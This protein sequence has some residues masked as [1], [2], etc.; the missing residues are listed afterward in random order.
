MKSFL[1]ISGDQDVYRTIHACLSPTSRVDPAS[2]VGKALEVL[3]KRRY[4]L[5]FVDLKF[6][7]E[8]EPD[9]GYKAALQTFWHLYPTIEIIV[10]ASNEMIREAVMCVKAGASDYLTYPLKPDEVSHVTESIYESVILQSELEYLRDQ[11]WQVDSLEVVQTRNPLMRR[12]FDK[13]RSVASTKSTV[14]FIGE[15]GTGKGVLAKLT[16]QHSNRRDC[17]FVSVHCGAIPDTLLESELF[18]HEKGA[19]TGADRRKLGKFE[20]ARGGTIFL[21][22]IGTITP[23]AQIK[24]L[25]ILQDGTFQRVG[26]EQTLEANVRI[27]VATNSDL[28][29]M[30]DD[31]QF[32]RDLYYRLNVFPIE[33]PPLRERTEDIPFLA[34]VFLK[35]LNRSHSK[36][37][38]DIH[39]DVM[40]AFRNYDW[41]GNIREMENL[42]ERAYILETSSVLTPE[43]FPL[44]LFASEKPSASVPVDTSSTLTEV[45]R[46]G[47]EDIERRY[48]KEILA[49]NNGRIKQ[50]AETAGITPRQL[51]KLMTKYKIRKE[52]F[53]SPV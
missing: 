20:I 36:E 2:N 1:V 49:Q 15:T 23:S 38:H 5:L 43:S 4:D 30:C 37:I 7:K 35:K 47:L 48:L 22:E 24:L 17:Q 13:I 46:R 31:G 14:L 45:R 12:L 10:M 21:D 41:P 27:V 52:E 9:K 40:E 51:H 32:R 34:E 53:K 29:R 11:F 16:H 26:G 28:K 18:G 3:R 25:Q 42:M 50:S 33:V 19:F 8:A 6:L 39:P 44:E